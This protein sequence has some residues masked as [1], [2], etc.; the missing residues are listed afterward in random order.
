MAGDLVNG[1]AACS[2]YW[3]RLFTDRPNLLGAAGVE[4]A[5]SGWVD[6]RGHLA[7]KD[8][9]FVRCIGVARQCGREERPG[10]GVF[11]TLEQHLTRA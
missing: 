9:F 10:V 11:R 2:K 6:R 5:A 1:A 3:L 8:D 4:A 7:R